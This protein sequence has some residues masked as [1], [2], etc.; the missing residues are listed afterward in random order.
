LAEIMAAYEPVD[1]L[2]G[3]IKEERNE[4]APGVAD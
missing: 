4:E 3:S 2:L 1:E